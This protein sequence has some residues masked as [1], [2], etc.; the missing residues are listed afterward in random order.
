V[1]VSV[2]WYILDE[3]NETG[4]LVEVIKVDQQ[5]EPGKPKDSR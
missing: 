1:T 2:G 5:R 3:T 4:R